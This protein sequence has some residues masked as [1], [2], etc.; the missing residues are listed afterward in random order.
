MPEKIIKIDHEFGGN[1]NL[2]LE[3]SEQEPALKP[4]PLKYRYLVVKNAIKKLLN[5]FTGLVVR[6][7]QT[8]NNATAYI[9]FNGLLNN[10]KMT[11]EEIEKFGD[12]LNFRLSNYIQPELRKLLTDD[13]LN[14]KEYYRS[15]VY[16]EYVIQENVLIVSWSKQGVQDDVR[17]SI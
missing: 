1:A 10:P 2:E 17:E 15:N 11:E 16:Y 9:N 6:F 7:E 12:E 8:K 4:V 3:F 5:A 13:G 14:Y